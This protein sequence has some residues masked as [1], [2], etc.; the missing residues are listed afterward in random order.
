MNLFPLLILS[1]SGQITHRKWIKRKTPEPRKLIIKDKPTQTSSKQPTRNPD[2]AD[3][4]HQILTLNPDGGYEGIKII[5]DPSIQQNYNLVHR[6]ISMMTAF[7]EVLYK[8]SKKQVHLGEIEIVIPKSWSP[9]VNESL[10]SIFDT[11]NTT[12]KALRTGTFRI[13]PKPPLPTVPDVLMFSASSNNDYYAYEVDDF[14]TKNNLLLGVIPP[15]HAVKG[16]PCSYPGSYIRIFEEFISTSYN[17]IVKNTTVSRILTKEWAKFRWGVF[18]ETPIP[19]QPFYSHSD[20]TTQ[21]TRCSLDVT[22]SFQRYNPWQEQMVQCKSNDMIDCK[23]IPD[24]VQK[25]PNLA[26]IMYTS[27]SDD[28]SLFCNNDTHNSEAPTA[29]NIRCSSRSV[30]DVISKHEDISNTA[31]KYKPP[32]FK[33]T[34]SSTQRVCLLLDTST[35]MFWNDRLMKVRQA[36]FTYLNIIPNNNYVS[37]VT[38]AKYA[39]IRSMLTEIKDADSR[40]WLSMALPKTR[41]ISRGTSI[42]R[43]LNACMDTFTKSGPKELRTSNSGGTIILLSDGYETDASS[44]HGLL[45]D[46]VYQKFRDQNIVVNT[47]AFGRET[48]SKLQDLSK[49]TGGQSFYA[50]PPEGAKRSNNMLEDSFNSI[51][52][53]SNLVNLLSNQTDLL[54]FKTVN[55]TFSVDP[56][57]GTSTIIALTYNTDIP[58]KLKL[59]TTSFFGNSP[60]FE[61]GNTV[62]DEWYK[63]DKIEVKFTHVVDNQQYQVQIVG[64]LKPGNYTVR[65]Q[66]IDP[67]IPSMVGSLTVS[68]YPNIESASKVIEIEQRVVQREDPISGRQELGIYANIRSGENAILD[69]VVIAEIS[70]PLK[71]DMTG[72][73]EEDIITL[74]LQDDGKS[75]DNLENDGIYSGRFVKLTVSGEYSVKTYA[76]SNGKTY[77]SNNHLIG[78]G[79]FMDT[80][81]T[82]NPETIN[83]NRITGGHSVYLQKVSRDSEYCKTGYQVHGEHC[84][85]YQKK[86]TF[87][88]ALK[89]CEEEKAQIVYVESFNELRFLLENL[90]PRRPPPTKSIWISTIEKDIVPQLSN[91][92]EMFRRVVTMAKNSPLYRANN[93]DEM[94]PSS[95]LLKSKQLYRSSKIKPKYSEE[96]IKKMQR[97][98]TLLDQLRLQSEEIPEN[99]HCVY[100]EVGEVTKDNIKFITD[101]RTCD[102]LELDFICK[103]PIIDVVEPARV[104]D[105]VGVLT[106][107]NSDILQNINQNVTDDDDDYVGLTSDE[108]LEIKEEKTNL[109]ESVAALSDST[110]YEGIDIA[111]YYD[112]IEDASVEYDDLYDTLTGESLTEDEE[113]ELT[114]RIL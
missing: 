14:E 10:Y 52:Q 54:P 82:V 55:Y 101:K 22:G 111:E 3:T 9:P 24:Y 5:F 35:S 114:G 23:F 102:N 53:N 36:A 34:Q 20:R 92:V 11:K 47:I 19:G 67:I 81:K 73:K 78:T 41:D 108:I 80:Y 91:A 90:I 103:R 68:T 13:I 58:P 112:I 26:S 60:V 37:I 105:F 110:D 75:E 66:N 46:E 64:K 39:V 48:T 2:L 70:R 40:E 107:S 89:V 69:A 6:L 98:G 21:G 77:I 99:Y 61:L 86:Q 65:L 59:L 33:I 96:F 25:R 43:A 51:L 18:D 71:I 17:V 15:P 38:F 79:V 50:T 1:I 42:S 95:V 28:I 87:E 76:R 97:S 30:W 63:D 85:L 109:F 72:A 29:Q 88:N 56:T 57:V 94:E 106:S 31:R 12:S 16:T 104:V 44:E 100:V 83:F 49:V 84:Y 8:A 93:L 4:S 32:T 45:S 62:T 7:S 27:I 74:R 113:P